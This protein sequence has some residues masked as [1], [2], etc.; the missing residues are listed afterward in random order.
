[1]TPEEKRAKDH[2]AYAFFYRLIERPWFN[3]TI[4]L[5]IFCSSLTLA[6][7]TYDQ[8]QTERDIIE[9][10]DYIY[11]LAFVVEFVCKMIGLGPYLYV[12]DAFNIMDALIVL[13]SIADIVLFKTV[14][15]KDDGS[16]GVSAIMA[17]SLLRVM[18]LARIWKQFQTMLSQIK[19]SIS[20]T[21]VFS[22]LLF[23]FLFIF[24]LLGMEL[25][26][27]AIFFD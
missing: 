16:V 3:F 4:Y 2:C 17:L 6:L 11:T 20:D 21:S 14:L 5:L 9:G 22:L 18:R 13:I 27:Y 25:F 24:A 19:N 8:T 23:V 26:A 10:L 1:M 7:Y 15:S 12:K